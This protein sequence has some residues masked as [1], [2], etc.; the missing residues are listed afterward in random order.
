MR[1]LHKNTSAVSEAIFREQRQL[2]KERLL[3]SPGLIC[4]HSDVGGS[5]S[6]A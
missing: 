1:L 5:C 2:R 3:A 4:D 6:G